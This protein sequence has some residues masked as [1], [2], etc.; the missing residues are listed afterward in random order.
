MEGARQHS[1]D[2]AARMTD[3]ALDALQHAQPEE[4]AGAALIDLANRLLKRN[5]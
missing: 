4:E 2:A 3:Q 5:L 1:L